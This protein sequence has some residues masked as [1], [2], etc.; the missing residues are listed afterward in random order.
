MGFLIFI[1]V[2]AA[3]VGTAVAVASSV[4]KDQDQ[5]GE[6]NEDYWDMSDGK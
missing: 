4:V 1:L 3:L 2:F 6:D 5:R